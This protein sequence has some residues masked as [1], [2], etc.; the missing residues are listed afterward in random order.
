[1]LTS[2]LQKKRTEVL[3]KWLSLLV[4]TYPP[5]SVNF[6][7]NKKNQFANPVGCTF[8]KELGILLDS[9]IGDQ[10]AEVISGALHTINKIRAVQD[11]SASEAVA[12]IFFLKTAIREELGDEL[13]DTKVLKELLSLESA[14]D[15]MGLIAFDTYMQNRETLNQIKFSDFKRRSEFFG[16]GRKRSD[17]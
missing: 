17:S 7:L 2:L 6:F 8:A 10:N 1:M 9:L 12:Y 13:K 14:I 15:G 3:D 4:N 11:F 16:G 5:E